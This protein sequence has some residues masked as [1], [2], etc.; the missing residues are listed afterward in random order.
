MIRALLLRVAVLRVAL[1]PRVC[2][3]LGHREQEHR[4]LL[5]GGGASVFAIC[6]RCGRRR[7]VPGGWKGPPPP[8]VEAFPGG[9]PSGGRTDGTP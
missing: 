1:R 2:R 7:L 3:V 4:A 8:P 5:H 9:A 6:A